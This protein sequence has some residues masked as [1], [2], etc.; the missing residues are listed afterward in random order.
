MQDIDETEEE[1]EGW[2]YLPP[3]E[4]RKLQERKTALMRE[5]LDRLADNT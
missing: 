3:E 4:V 5:M 2:I 1:E